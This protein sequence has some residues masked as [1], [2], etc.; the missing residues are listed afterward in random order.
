M[1]LA[2]QIEKLTRHLREGMPELLRELRSQ[3]MRLVAIS[4]LGLDEEQLAE[5]LEEQG[6]ADCFD[7]CYLLSAP[8]QVEDL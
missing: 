7:A 2:L 4:E 1:E 6:I 5:L 8:E 3:G